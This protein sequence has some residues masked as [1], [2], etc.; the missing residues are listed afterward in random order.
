M[1]HLHCNLYTNVVNPS[2]VST[3]PESTH[4]DK[5]P[6]ISCDCWNCRDVVPGG[7]QGSDRLA[8]PSQVQRSK[9]LFL[10]AKVDARSSSNN[11]A[12]PHA[13]FGDFFWA[14]Q[15]LMPSTSVR[16]SHI[17]THAKTNSHPACTLL[18]RLPNE[19]IFPSLAGGVMHTV[20][21]GTGLC[22]QRHPLP[23]HWA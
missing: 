15:T 4:L 22:D 13:H 21:E 5:P 2:T 18:G 10:G 14:S 12:L 17:H 3:R 7:G 1:R 16:L 8:A 9:P 20:W 11:G 6:N 23:L 19:T